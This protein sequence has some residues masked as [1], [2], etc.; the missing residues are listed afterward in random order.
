MSERLSSQ[1]TAQLMAQLVARPCVLVFAGLDPS[2]GAGIAADLQAVAG[3]GAHAL[4]VATA[5][6]VQ[7]NDR[8]YGVQPVDGAMVLRQAQALVDKVTVCA[9]KIGIPGSAA[10]AL[11]I[12]EI[13]ARLRARQPELPVVLDPVL[14]SG[15]GDLLSRDDAVQALAPLLPLVT[16]ITPNGPEALALTGVADPA[17]QAQALR[18]RGCRHVLITGGHG[19]G[20]EVVNRWFG[21]GAT[22]APRLSDSE[23]PEDARDWSWPRLAGEFHGSGCTL[24]SAIAGQ[25]ALGMSIERALELAQQYCYRALRGAYTV[26]AGQRIPQRLPLI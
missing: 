24:A 17:A 18:A 23:P 3:Q 20:D 5:L 8:V 4:T 10:N 25:L 1:M 13:I 15:H 12:A 21:P 2:G 14:T 19:E 22:P 26:A 16:V 11:A 9:V 7:D 6:T